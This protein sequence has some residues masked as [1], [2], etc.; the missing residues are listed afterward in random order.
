MKRSLFTILLSL[1]VI[2]CGTNL[3]AQYRYPTTIPWKTIKPPTWFEVQII[4][5]GGNH[6]SGRGLGQDG[7]TANNHYWVVENGTIIGS[8]HEENVFITRK[9]YSKKMN[10]MYWGSSART[11]QSATIYLEIPKNRDSPSPGL[12]PPGNNDGA[13]DF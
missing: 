6:F 4:Y 1:F 7:I 12:T 11:N 10:I 13:I 5:H 2:F 3:Y 9:D 8:S